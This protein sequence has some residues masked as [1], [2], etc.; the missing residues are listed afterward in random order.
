VPI[1]GA[2]VRILDD[3]RNKL[4]AGEPGEICVSSPAVMRGYWR[5]PAATADAIR[6]GWLHT[7]DIGYLDEEGYLFIVDR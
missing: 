2:V 3:F 1:P 7:G 5:A 6:D 4:P